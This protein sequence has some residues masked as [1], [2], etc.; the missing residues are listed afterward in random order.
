MRLYFCDSPFSIEESDRLG[1]EAAA[2][3]HGHSL[4]FFP[5]ALLCHIVRRLAEDEDETIAGAVE[6]AAKTLS[7]L[8]PS[9]FHL[10]HMLS[11]L[12]KAVTLAESRKTDDLT[13][14]HQIGEGWVGDEALCIAVYCALRYS[15]DY[16]GAVRTAVNHNGDSDSTGSLCGNIMGAKLGYDAIPAYFKKN[17]ELHDTICALADALCH[18]ENTFLWAH[19]AAVDPGTGLFATYRRDFIKGQ[20][21]ADYKRDIRKL[22]LLSGRGYTAERAADLME[23]RAVFIRE[24]YEEEQ[25]ADTA[26]KEIAYE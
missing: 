8:Y 23:E 14:I 5:A 1:A 12:D 16:E 6:D 10:P 18:D 3:T 2:I 20:P 21:F 26:V 19:N 15:D 13:A 4:G 25:P 17:L 22:L 11:R 24:A 9:I 7:G